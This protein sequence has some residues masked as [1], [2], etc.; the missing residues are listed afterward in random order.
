VRGDEV[1]GFTHDRASQADFVAVPA[2]QLAPKPSGVP[3]E[4]AGS[5]FVAGTTAYAVV[6]AVALRE[7]ETVVVS[8]AAGGVGTLTV[9]LARN[10]GARVLG[11]ASEHHHAW[12][13]QHG[14]IPITYGEGVEARIRDAAGGPVDAFIDTFG[15]GYVELAINLGVAPD[16]IDTIA[17]RAGAAKYGVKTAGNADAASADVLREL[18][19]LVDKGLLEVPIAKVYPLDA[20]Q[21]AFRELE[22][23][24]TIGK[25]VL[26]P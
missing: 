20:V 17:D 9:Q 16:R 7:G 23:R 14:V 26:V 24:H 6:R 13:E 18:A 21:D 22:E 19:S 12:L 8:G 3:W 1:I 11:L 5:L 10:V 4:V 25:I 2:E 15:G